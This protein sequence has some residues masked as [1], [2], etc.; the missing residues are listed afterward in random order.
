MRS[1]NID[2]LDISAFLTWQESLPHPQ[3]ALIQDR[4]ESHGEP[5]RRRKGWEMASRQ[6]LNHLAATLAGEY[7]VTESDRFLALA[8]DAETAASLLLF[9]GGSH[10][11]LLSVLG[12]VV[13]F[14]APGKQVVVALRGADD[15][16]RYIAPFYDEG[17]YA[18]SGGIQVREGYPHIVV[19]GKHLGLLENAL[20]HEMTHAGLHHL[21][22]PQ[23]LEEGLA[24][25]AEHEIT[26][27]ELLIV[28]GELAGRHKRFWGKHGLDAFWSGE[29]FSR[30][31]KMQAL[32]YQLAE[33]LVRLLFEDARP[34][35][36][37]WVQEPRRRLFAF[38]RTAANAD[39][40]ESACRE[41]LGMGRSELAARFLGPGSWA[42]SS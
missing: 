23:W 39:K 40:G 21:S 15:Y 7:Q 9:A 12:E 13:Q 31:G 2:E 5:D 29:G 6:W 20:A 36:F 16:Y 33:I 37:G 19:Y 18:T 11:R 10:D 35:W 38:L 42:P 34:R 32:S 30:P 27:R 22:M 41:F 1:M 25:M 26:G 4:I 17:H 8:P 28:D 24:Q 3:W 14:A